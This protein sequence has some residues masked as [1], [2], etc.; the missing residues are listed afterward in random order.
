MNYI[1]AGAL[2][3]L[4]NAA[5]AVGADVTDPLPLNQSGR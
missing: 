2:G 4:R 3:G 5:D 1:T